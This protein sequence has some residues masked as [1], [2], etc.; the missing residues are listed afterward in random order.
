MFPK[1]SYLYGR[2]L[3]LRLLGLVYLVAFASLWWQVE[4]LVG[5]DGIL[6]V[7]DF[8]ERVRANT[9]AERYWQVPTL[10]WLGH[11]D[12]ALHLLCGSGVLLSLALVVGIAPLPVGR[13]AAEGG[14]GRTAGGRR[15]L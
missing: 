5:A 15:G 2:W 13:P 4:G 10:L 6:P 7:A 11:G 12:L 14:R 8:L 9:G 1:G 3:F